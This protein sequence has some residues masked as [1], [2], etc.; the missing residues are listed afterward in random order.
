MYVLELRFNNVA[1]YDKFE[2]EKKR[3]CRYSC[4]KDLPEGFACLDL[5]LGFVC[6]DLPLGFV[7][8]ADISLSG[9]GVCD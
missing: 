6:L 9:G 4:F 2:R 8:L 1:L 3:A 5:P 7:R